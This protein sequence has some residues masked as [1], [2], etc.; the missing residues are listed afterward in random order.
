VTYVLLGVF[1]MNWVGQIVFNGLGDRIGRKPILIGGMLVGIG[2][3]IGVSLPYTYWLFAS[4]ALVLGFALAYFIQAFVLASEFTHQGNRDWFLICSHLTLDLFS[5]IHTVVFTITYHAE[6]YFLLI[7]ALG[8]LVI[9]SVI[10]GPDSP[11]QALVMG[12]EEKARAIFVRFAKWT[13]DTELV[14]KY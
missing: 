8:F 11:R 14:K 9:T 2:V 5:L 12:K 6:V 4:Y 3:F 7:A 10:V 13:G 1:T